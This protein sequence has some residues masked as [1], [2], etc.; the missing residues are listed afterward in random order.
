M[1]KTLVQKI[2]SRHLDGRDVNP[3]EAVMLPIDVALGNDASTNGAISVLKKMNIDRVFDPAKVVTVADH[4]APA[5]DVKSAILLHMMK[6]WSDQQ[7]VKHYGL[8][9]GGIEHTVLI[10]EGWIVP[11]SVIAGGDSHTCTYGA[12]GAFGTGVGLTDLACCLALGA[13]WQVVPETIRVAFKGQKPGFVAGKDLILSVLGVLGVSGATGAVLEFTGDGAESLSIDD[14]MAVSNMA[15]EAG[16][17]TGF[18]PAD[19]ITRDYLKGRTDKAWTAE[20]SDPDAD[21]VRTVQVDLET[22]SPL[23]A[24]PSSPGNVAEVREVCGRKIDQVYLGNCANGT[25]TDL[26]QAASILKGNKVHPDTR[27]IV[28]PASQ[29]VW[30]QASEEGLLDIFANAGAAVSMPTCGA[31]FGGHNGVMGPGERALTTTNRNFKGRMGS[32][33]AEVYI[34]NAYVAAASAIAGEISEPNQFAD[35]PEMAS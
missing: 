30:L 33:E 25:I 29:R 14:R 5:K 27:M 21:I 28:V 12:L 2:M 34:A 6:I 20:H 11:G 24:L 18:F 10:E 13:F 9:R 26:R 3:G 4:F 32:P 19:Q 17:E 16:S 1:G 31:C 8:G 23:I 22:I 35:V 15:V 7:G